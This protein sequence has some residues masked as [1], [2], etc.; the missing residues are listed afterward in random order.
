[1]SARDG[2]LAQ[3]RERGTV[4]NTNRAGQRRLVAVRPHN[5]VAGK[6][7]SCR[8]G[9]AGTLCRDCAW[10]VWHPVRAADVVPGF[11]YDADADNR[12]ARGSTGCE[13][14]IGARGRAL[15]RQFFSFGDS[16]LFPEL[17]QRQRWVHAILAGGRNAVE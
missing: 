17:V 9:R 6:M 14:R 7:R 13:G 12:R 4:C 5:R 15:A 1:M 2:A 3:S 11:R 10:M 8:G 16:F